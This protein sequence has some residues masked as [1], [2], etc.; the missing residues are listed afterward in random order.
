MIHNIT[1]TT[2]DGQSFTMTSQLH[3]DVNHAIDRLVALIT[4]CGLVPQHASWVSY[5]GA[6]TL[7]F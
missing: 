7:T 5:K 2:T 4:C 6:T 1:L 3:E